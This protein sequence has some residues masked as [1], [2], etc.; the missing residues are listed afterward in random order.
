MIHENDLPA[1]T[2]DSPNIPQQTVCYIDDSNDQ[3]A[4]KDPALL[5]T[6]IQKRADNLISWLSDNRMVIA[7]A[8]TKLMI[9]SN[10]Q[11][12]TARIKDFD[13][14]VTVLNKE[15]RPT[16]SEKLL[17]II[18]SDDMTWLPHLW[19]ESWRVKDNARGL[20]PE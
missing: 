18:L 6:K 12:K 20:I 15:I 17:G 13:F 1:A 8:K 10:P 5:M 2:P 16:P 9:T 3:V 4:A 7:P 11:M 14:K 19:G